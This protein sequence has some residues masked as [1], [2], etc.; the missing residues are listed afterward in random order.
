[1]PRAQGCTRAAVL[2]SRRLRHTI[3]MMLLGDIGPAG[4]CVRL[5]GGNSVSR[6]LA[7]ARVLMTARSPF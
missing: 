7:I 2:K 3:P 4:A 6:F 5:S 1:M